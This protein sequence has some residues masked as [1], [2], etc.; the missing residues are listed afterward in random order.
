VHGIPAYLFFSFR[1]SSILHFSWVV[2]LQNADLSSIPYF[3]NYFIVHWEGEQ[4]I[5]ECTD[6]DDTIVMQRRNAV[7]KIR[8]AQ[9]RNGLPDG[10]RGRA[11]PR[12]VDA[13]KFEAEESDDMDDSEDDYVDEGRKK[14]R[15]SL[16]QN[17]LKL[18]T[19]FSVSR[20][21]DECP[22]RH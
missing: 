19:A 9:Q 20:V 10:K 16:S 4:A 15:F 8:P 13:L 22:R 17:F 5:E 1:L 11:D 2:F 6:E 12:L 21:S 14:V 18:M 3:L 7:L